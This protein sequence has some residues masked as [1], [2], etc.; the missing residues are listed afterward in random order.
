MFHGGALEGIRMS[1]RSTYHV[2]GQKGSWDVKQ[3]GAG[4]SV[5]HHASKEAAVATAKTF[6]KISG[7]GQVK[8]HGTDGKIQTEYTYG[9]DPRKSKG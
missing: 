4:Y 7:L 5:S 3:A 6:A 1:K 8:I 2:V 9:S